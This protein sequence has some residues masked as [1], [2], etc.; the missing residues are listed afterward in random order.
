MVHFCPLCG[1]EKSEY[2]LLCEDCT[3]KFKNEYEVSFPEDSKKKSDEN[4]GAVSAIVPSNRRMKTNPTEE[5]QHRKPE[6]TPATL[7]NKQDNTTDTIH[8][9]KIKKKPKKR[10][11]FITLILLVITLLVAAGYRYKTYIKIQNI[12]RAAWENAIRAQTISGYL[13]YMDTYPSGKYFIEAQK[14]ML[15]LKAKESA[16]WEKL[17]HSHNT[18]EFRDFLT[19]YPE[20]PYRDLVKSRMDSL[21]WQAALKVN[22]A[23]SYAHYITL[24]DSRQI[25]G[26]YIAEAEKRFGMLHQKTIENQADL[27]AI[28]NTIDGFYIGISTV[29]FEKLTT[30]LA[31]RLYRF[32]YSGNIESS[33]IIGK[34]MMMA[35]KTGIK[36]MNFN[37]NT[38]ALA[39]EKTEGNIFHVNV[40][41]KKNYTDKSG[42]PQQV[43]GYI[44][45]IELT[46]DFKIQS[47]YETKPYP[48][49]P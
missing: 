11:L 44:A 9:V 30:Y 2:T 27:D 31:P 3:R 45:H 13:S 29:S 37:V 25:P 46:P 26:E 40:P 38:D 16:A 32:F 7:S 49:A 17:Q 21:T 48:S 23:Q 5:N 8:P 18:A 14:S 12:E 42:A 36:T 24:F 19:Q 43:L 28:R 35:A 34:L 41:L 1:K 10:G 6:Q 20:S 4:E 15:N 39:Y 22:E 33:K 47:V